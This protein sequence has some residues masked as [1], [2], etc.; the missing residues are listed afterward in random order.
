MSG[1]NLQLQTVNLPKPIPNSHARE[2]PGKN[3][4]DDEATEDTQDTESL[5]ELLCTLQKDNLLIDQEAQQCPRGSPKVNK[6]PCALSSLNAGD[7]NPT[8]AA[9]HQPLSPAGSTT[10]GT[11]L[12][13]SGDVQSDGED[14]SGP[15]EIPSPSTSHI[16]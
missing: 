4:V 14:S 8:P 15:Q 7:E 13:C 16:W 9:Q 11:T 12:F 6:S 3:N 2:R 10:S 5:Y 1:T